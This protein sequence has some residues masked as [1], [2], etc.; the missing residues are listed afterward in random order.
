MNDMNRMRQIAFDLQAKLDMLAE[1]NTHL[2]EAI[3]NLER[4]IEEV[5]APEEYGEDGE[6]SL[7]GDVVTAETRITSHC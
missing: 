4:Y 3:W 5:I 2:K 6:T 1:P 7:S